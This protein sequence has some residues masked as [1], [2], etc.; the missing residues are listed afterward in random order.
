MTIR[1]LAAPMTMAPPADIMASTWNSGPST[2]S[3]RRYPSAASAVSSMAMDTTIW[4]KTSKP[5]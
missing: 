2:P 1:S 3:R 5:S 4:M